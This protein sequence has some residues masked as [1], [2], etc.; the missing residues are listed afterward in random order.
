MRLCPE[1]LW[2]CRPDGSGLELLAWGLRNP[3]GLAFR[4]ASCTPPKRTTRRRASAP[5]PRTPTAEKT[6]D[7]LLIQEYMLE[8]GPV[9]ILY[10]E[11]P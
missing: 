10:H 7:Q 8:M 4:G 1:G 6:K 5:S 11:D 2:R 3:Y 9:S